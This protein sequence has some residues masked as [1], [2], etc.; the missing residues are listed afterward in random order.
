MCAGCEAPATV[1]FNSN[2]TLSVASLFSIMVAV[3]VTPS[4]YRAQLIN[5]E[6]TTVGAGASSPLSQS[7][8]NPP[9]TNSNNF[10]LRCF[11]L[12]NFLDLR[13]NKYINIFLNLVKIFKK[14]KLKH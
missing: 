2:S 14:S 5:F 12:F 6:L 3:P 13:L 7:N 11:I 10:T 1:F 4:S 8:K 9:I